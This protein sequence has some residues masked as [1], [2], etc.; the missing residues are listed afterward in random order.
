MSVTEKSRSGRTADEQT[1]H[2]A[3]AAPK[4]QK[5]RG[6]FIEPGQSTLFRS[7]VTPLDRWIARKMMQIVGNPPIVLKLWD[8]AEVMPPV[9]NPVARIRYNNRG[10]MLKTIINPELYWG[11]LYLSLIHI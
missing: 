8:G 3:A 6:H 1:A 11:D 4:K 10:A 5:A 9:E 7:K 2:D